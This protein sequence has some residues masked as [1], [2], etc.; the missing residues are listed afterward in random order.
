MPTAPKLLTSESVGEGSAC[1]FLLPRILAGFPPQMVKDGVLLLDQDSKAK[2]N[3]QGGHAK[4]LIQFVPS[5][6]KGLGLDQSKTSSMS[7][8]EQLDYVDKFYDT[9]NHKVTPNI[10]DLFFP[11]EE[12]H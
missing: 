11:Q 2:T 8:V 5:T 9:C 1:G 4:G 7:P 3:S 6:A 10:E 12:L